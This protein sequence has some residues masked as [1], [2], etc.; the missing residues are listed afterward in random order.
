[1]PK[2][3]NLYL[4]VQ[5]GQFGTDVSFW[6]RPAT[7]EFQAVLDDFLSLDATPDEWDDP[8]FDRLLGE[9]RRRFRET[10][11][12]EGAVMDAVLGY[13]MQEMPLTRRVLN[14]FRSSREVRDLFQQG[15]TRRAIAMAETGAAIR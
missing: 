4:P 12:E 13:V 6:H 9:F 7:P 3:A 2:G 1:V 10:N 5:G 11:T 15:V 14:E 8:S